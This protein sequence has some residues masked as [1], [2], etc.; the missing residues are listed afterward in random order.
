MDAL[1][2]HRRNDLRHDRDDHRV[3]C[4]V[5]RRDHR[6]MDE[7][8]GQNDLR[9][10]ETKCHR[11]GLKIDSPCYDDHRL[12]LGDRH[13]MGYHGVDDLKLGVN[14]D[15]SHD[16]CT[17]DQLDDHLKDDDRHDVLDVRRM[18]E[19]DDRSDLTMVVSLD[20]SLDV[21]LCHRRSDRLDD[22]RMNVTDDRNLDGNHVNRNYAPRGLKMDVNLDAMSHHAMLMDDLSMNCDRM[23][24]DHL[25]CG[26]LKMRHRDKNQMGGKNLDVMI[27]DG[28]LKNSDAMNSDARMI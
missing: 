28:K 15:V 9:N 27:L 24:R 4:I 10:H 18:N 17:N 16:L 8:T 19:M 21:S 12:P 2:D 11:V 14:L 25:R 22:H 3:R 5:N 1:R 7:K 13:R 26:H 20:V 23:S 6:V